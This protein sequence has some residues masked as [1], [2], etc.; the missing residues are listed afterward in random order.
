VVPNLP[1]HIELAIRDSRIV[2]LTRLKHCNIHA[3]QCCHQH[4][5]QSHLHVPTN[6]QLT[7]IVIS[8]G[9]ELEISQAISLLLND[10]PSEKTYAIIS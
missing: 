5:L 8:H 10:N 3:I 6:T 1:P 2:I 4:W 7:E 9:I